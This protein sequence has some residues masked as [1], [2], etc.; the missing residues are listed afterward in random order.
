MFVCC[1]EISIIKCYCYMLVLYTCS[2]YWNY[3]GFLTAWG[4]LL[5]FSVPGGTKEIAGLW[6]A[7]ERS[8]P[9]L[10]LWIRKLGKHNIKGIT[11]V[12]PPP[13]PLIKGGGLGPS[14]NWVTW[15]LPK[16]FLER[17]DNPEK[18]GDWC[19]NGGLPLF[20][21][22]TVQFHLLCVCVC[23]GGGVKF[24]LLHFD[25]SVF[26]VN[27]TRFS[28]KSIVLKHCIICIFLIHSNSVQKMLTALF[29]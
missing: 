7:R 3:Q 1:F 20:Y 22:F 14:K 19:R 17:G 28:S 2:K 18:K 29:I 4:D 16:I 8:V 23:G 27:H 9:R 21:Y 5:R 6:F 25:S 12:D 11:I 10:T 24:A 15:G 13:P 26:W